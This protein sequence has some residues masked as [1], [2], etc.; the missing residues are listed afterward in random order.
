MSQ[1][2]GNIID[3]CKNYFYDKT[4]MDVFLNNKSN[5]GHT[6][7][8]VTKETRT[9]YQS[10]SI[11]ISAMILDFQ[12]AKII[13]IDIHTDKAFVDGNKVIIVPIENIPQDLRPLSSIQNWDGKLGVGWIFDENG[14]CVD[15]TRVIP[16]LTMSINLNYTIM[17]ND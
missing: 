7:Q 8:F 9:F 10:G 4:D 15:S 13:Q 16:N 1:L 12:I 6:H 3:I 5:V 2:I 17:D 11:V 14:I